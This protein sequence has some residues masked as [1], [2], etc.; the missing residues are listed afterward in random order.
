MNVAAEKLNGVSTV[1]SIMAPANSITLPDEEALALGGSVFRTDTRGSSGRMDAKA[2]ASASSDAA[3][4]CTRQPKAF[5]VSSSDSSGASSG[6]SSGV[7]SG[8][9]AD[10]SSEIGAGTSAGSVGGSG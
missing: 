8:A 3:L 1:Y 7:F 6:T 2:K 9:S 5:S 10:A 4:S